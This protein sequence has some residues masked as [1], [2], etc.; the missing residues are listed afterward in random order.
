MAANSGLICYDP[1]TV[2]PYP[3]ELDLSE[4]PLTALRQKVRAMLSAK[5][6]PPK[7]LLTE[8][9]LPRD[10]R[11]ILHCARLNHGEANLV[12]SH[13]NPM[14]SVLKLW[15]D[16]VRDDG[17]QGAS[18]A[19][20]IAALEVIDRF[21]VADDIKE[22]LGKCL[23][24]SIACRRVYGRFSETHDVTR[25]LLFVPSDKQTLSTI[26]WLIGFN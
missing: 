4:V 6:N 14:A 1:E 8:E 11:G 15:C 21:D 19:Q 12:H 13:P 17:R 2:V 25:R 23:P 20:L 24:L 18:F 5:L 9:G 10:W 16:A 22:T 3:T 26:S 7:I